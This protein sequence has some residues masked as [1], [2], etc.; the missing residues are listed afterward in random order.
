MPNKI[1]VS[2][3]IE[4]DQDLNIDKELSLVLKRLQVRDV[5]SRKIDD[6]QTDLTYT[7]ENLDIITILQ[8]E[9]V[10]YGKGKS[11]SQKLRGRSYI[12]ANENGLDSEKHYKE[13]MNVFINNYDNIIDKYT[14]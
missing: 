14:R 11:I 3:H 1:K 2:G 7:L 12:Y 10:I 4:I 13:A 9:D 5:K 8:G 6:D